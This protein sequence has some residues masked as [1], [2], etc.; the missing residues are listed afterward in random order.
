MNSL[1]KIDAIF[2]TLPE[3]LRGKNLWQNDFHKFDVFTHTT[4]CVRHLKEFSHDPNLIAAAWLHDVG[5]PAV[6]KP[7]LDQNGHQTE[8]DGKAYH[9]FKNHERVGQEIVENMP[10]EIFAGLGLDQQ[11][12]AVLVGSHYLPMQNIKELRKTSN[13]PDFVRK[14]KQLNDTLENLSVTKEEVLDIFVADSL[15]HGQSTIDQ[16]ELLLVREALLKPK[17]TEADLRHLY[18]IQKA[19][20]GGKE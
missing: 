3:I 18:D 4:E 8:K 11:K 2:S 17:V 9:T 16:P 10:P 13:F 6:A 20:Y 15:A 14:F 12:I 5:K 7:R 1:E 19:T